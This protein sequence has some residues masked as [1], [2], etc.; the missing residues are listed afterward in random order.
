MA[1]T[2]VPLSG[3]A[4]DVV[5]SISAG[6]GGGGPRIANVQIANSSWGLLDD[7]AVG[8]D[9]GYVLINGSGFAS[10]CS[11]LI[12]NTQASTVTFANSSLLRVQVPAK[13][14]STYVVYVLNPDGGTAIGVNALTY[15]AFPAWSTDST[16]TSGLV[17][18]AIS[19]QLS[20]SDAT[21]Y[22][23]QAGSSL[24]A[25]T[26]LAS[27]G[28]FSGTITGLTEETTYSFTVEAT[29]A[30]NQNTPRTF[31]ITI[32]AGDSNFK[33][34]T[35]LLNADTNTFVR[36]VSN[37]NF[38][39]TVNG[40]TR[41]SAFSPYN[42]NWSNYFDG[43]GDYL[44]IA[45]NASLELG[46]ESFTIECWFNIPSS[47]ST[48]TLLNKNRS[49][50]GAVGGFALDVSSTTI[51]MYIN[52]DSGTTLI[53]SVT[54]TV[55]L[56]TWNHIAVVRSVSGST[57]NYVFLNGVSVGTSSTSTAIIDNS[58][59]WWIGST[60]LSGSTYNLL[61][62]SISN[63]R[64]LKGTAL[65]TT[66]FTPPTSP[67]TA[68]S[69]TVLLTCQSNRFIDNSTNNFTITRNGD[70]A[71]KAS[72][73][74]TET[75][76]TTGSG[77]FDGSGDYLNTS[78]T[79]IIPASTTYSVEAWV[80][81][82]G[83]YSVYREI[84][85]QGSSGNANRW[86][87]YVNITDG[88][89]RIQTGTTS[90]TTSFVIPLNT[91]THVAFVNNA[92]S[93]NIY[94]NGTSVASG[95]SAMVPENTY[96]TVG[97]FQTGTEYFQGYISDVRISNVARSI[98]V[99]SSSYTSDNNTRLLTLQN[100]TG[101]T[102]HQFV[103]E[104]GFKHFITRA[105]N[106]TQGS[107]SPFS[108]SGWSGYF[109][110][111]GDYLTAT[112][113]TAAFDWWTTDSTIE[114]WVFPVSLTGWG[115]A[116]G[117]GSAT[118]PS[119]IGNAA[120]ASTSNYWSFGPYTDGTVKFK[121]WNGSAS[122]TVTSTNTITAGQWS[123]IAMVKTSSG[124][125]LYVNGVK[126]T[127]TAIV[128]TPVSGTEVPLIIGQINSASINGYVSNLRIVKGTALYNS[129]FTP[130]TAP[131]TPISNTSLLTLRGNSFTDD[132]P[133]RVAFTKAGNTSIVPFSP[134]KPHTI[135]ANS[136]SVYFDGTGDY[137]TT[138]VDSSLTSLGN[139]YTVEAWINLDNVTGTKAI[140]STSVSSTASY[141]YFI[142]YVSGS[143][144]A[145][146]VRPS[147]GAVE[148]GLV[149]GTL[150]AGVWNHVAVSV[151]SSVGKLFIN[152]AQVGSN[153]NIS[154]TTFTAAYSTIGADIIQSYPF[155]GSISNLRILKG[156][157][158]YT[159]NFTPPTSAL[160]AI[161]NTVLLAC[162]S[163]TLID[164]SNNAFSLT[165]AGD[166]IPTKFNPFGE[167]I[168]TNVDYKANTH[169][170]SL[171]LDGS[172]D[173]LF[174]PSSNAV[175][176][177][178]RNFTWEFW[179]YPTI[180]GSTRLLDFGAENLL[181]VDGANKF[182]YYQN[183]AKIT[184]AQAHILN[185]W[186]HVA[187]TRSANNTYMFINGV[188]AN[189]STVSD[190]V[191]YSNSTLRVGTNSSNSSPGA[192]Y[193]SNIRILNGQ[194]LYTSSFAPPQSPVQPTGNTTVLINSTH[195]GIIDA[196]GRNVLECIG[197][198]KVRTDTKKYGVGSMYFDGTGDYITLP[199]TNW[200]RLANADFTIECWI[201]L[202]ATQADMGIV[203]SYENNNG[204]IF[205]LGSN[206]IRFFAGSS[207]I[208]VDKTYSFSTNTWYHLAVAR[209][210]T[211]IRVFVDGSQ[212]G[213]TSTVGSA[214][215][216]TTQ[217]VYIGRTQTT[218]SDFN[219]YIDDLRV[220]RGVARYTTNFTP[221]SSAHLAR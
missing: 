70:V 111:S 168:A 14:A 24:P 202:A 145:F 207:E 142:F 218:T 154:A 123:H 10:G 167:T 15:S 77:Y 211:S 176:F 178:N 138:P 50:T 149:A 121:Y 190:T 200:V 139:T 171:F 7:T 156:T 125:T 6:A 114:A 136:H 78:T 117:G 98:T 9:G 26:T 137:I 163:S 88:T 188:R 148:S 96:L 59:P 19:I 63:L 41:P 21:T 44:S 23:L 89:L 84:V 32:T 187:V 66:N 25:N 164:N 194:A 51:R 17:D 64:I 112:Y 18:T 60:N 147:T 140:Y 144:L 83:D 85:T 57:T 110:G 214:T 86:L 216:T 185:T 45:D 219:G 37:N 42:T 143:N 67:L 181:Y 73:P 35:L 183:A 36:D 90:L 128:G 58:E 71:I 53:P 29:D 101:I 170:G 33:S 198:I 116:E 213:T 20:A 49:G 179:W 22:S 1:L 56:N 131:L 141:G 182:V 158:L 197:D 92:G 82:T 215:D 122:H 221:P 47:G 31:S 210:G 118:Q 48:Y 8:T 162:Q 5:D 195:G 43:T 124:I 175:A 206:F 193:F 196:S 173:F 80:Y 107:F 87:M 180:N 177:G 109:D 91:W 189:T 126:Q 127:T 55:P 133:Y 146:Y 186:Y 52:G 74:F 2:V 160:T 16:L 119:M 157:A 134:F 81:L 93:Y 199:F 62:G 174:V 209:S 166:V 61:A 184:S 172:G 212:V 68:I 220:T 155:K 106:A 135:T 95:S 79:Q 113:S 3:L 4:S 159:T 97:A 99:P 39:I 203:S 27:N 151:N 204:W 28:L 165:A 69:N 76:V 161:S 115:Y 65:Y 34:T 100:R 72:G 105:G 130:A 169:G 191:S 38:A 12:A 40:D 94:V 102:N 201:R 132:G 129:T 30:E 120:A 103:D 108:P 153:T 75:D 13:S 192:G 11:V 150:T 104:S 208:V 46:S 152:G 205:R 217:G 54:T